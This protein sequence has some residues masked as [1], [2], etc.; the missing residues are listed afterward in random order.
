MRE[1]ICKTHM[2]Q[3]NRIQN[4]Q[5]SLKLNNKKTMQKVAKDLNGHL[6]RED[7]EM[8]Q[9]HMKRWSTYVIR[10][11]QVKNKEMPLMT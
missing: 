1:N 2:R 9:K 7:T 3:R 6:I 5:R 4:I 8:A 11:L 10:G